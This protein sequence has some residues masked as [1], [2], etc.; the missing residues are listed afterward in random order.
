MRRGRLLIL[1]GLI[2]ILVLVAAVLYVPR[3]LG[4]QGTGEQ[5]P[6]IQATPTPEPVTVVITTQKIQRGELISED[7][8]QLVEIPQDN[9]IAQ[10]AQAINEV[11]GKRA[12]FDLEAGVYVTE[13]MLAKTLE[14]ISSA[15]SNAALL[16]GEGRV[17]VS[18]PINR[19]SSVSYGIRPG[20]RVV[21]IATM[22]FVDM[23]ATYQSKL[24]NSAS[25]VIAPGPSVV[26]TVADAEGNSATNLQSDELLQALTAQITTGGAV[27]PIGR[28]ELDSTLG[29]PFY[30]VP[31]ESQRPRL[32]SHGLIYDAVVL[33]VGDFPTEDEEIVPQETPTPAAEG[34]QPVVDETGQQVVATPEVKPPDVVTLIVSPQDAV[35]L[36]YMLYTG[37][38][39]SL[40]L[41]SA[42]DPSTIDTQ[43]VSLQFLLDQY[44]FSVPA[45]LPFGLEPRID[46]LEPPVLQNDVIVPTPQP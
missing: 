18:I 5:Q 1:L 31:S 15:G 35:V 25:A 23:D 13:G 22:L 8:V 11:V 27:S 19:L 6:E 3:L 2:L 46:V 4:G 21:V 24:P 9:V 45:K 17:A 30:V 26:I 44:Q 43:P 37:S 36:N 28:V 42:N 16:I 20:D 34:E 10:M 33:Q 12:K 40:A 7:V 39:L 38:Q 32:V 29:Q 41:R 14:E